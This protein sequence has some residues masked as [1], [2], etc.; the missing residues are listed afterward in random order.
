MLKDKGAY[1]NAALDARR[2]VT[3][4]HGSTWRCSISC[5]SIASFS[6]AETGAMRIAVH[7]KMHL[8]LVTIGTRNCASTPQDERRKSEKG[9]GVT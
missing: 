3:Q 5:S 7:V 9:N 2:H 8:R 6:I 1:Q 4:T